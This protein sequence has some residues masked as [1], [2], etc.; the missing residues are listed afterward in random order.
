MKRKEEQ[1]EMNLSVNI[2]TIET[3][4]ALNDFH[5]TGVLVNDEELVLVIRRKLW[6]S[7]RALVYINGCSMTLTGITMEFNSIDSICRARG[8]DIE[9]L[10]WED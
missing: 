6:E 9:T 10:N 1:I 5:D 2:S 3:R 4:Q 8:Y 7:I